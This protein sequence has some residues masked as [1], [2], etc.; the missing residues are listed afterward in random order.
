MKFHK[1][2]G[3]SMT[4]AEKKPSERQEMSGRSVTSGK[5]GDQLCRRGIRIAGGTELIVLNCLRFKP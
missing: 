4:G 1:E 2:E 5:A 3:L